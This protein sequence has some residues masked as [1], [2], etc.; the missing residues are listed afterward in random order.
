MVLAESIDSHVLQLYA[1]HTLAPVMPDEVLEYLGDAYQRERAINTE[2]YFDLFA[3]NP[4]RF[5]GGV[6]PVEH[7]PP[8]GFTD[9]LRLL[10]R[11]RRVLGELVIREGA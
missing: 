10:P 5:L 9:F 4:G 11:Q 8:E 2:T 7:A 1:E 6:R 3:C